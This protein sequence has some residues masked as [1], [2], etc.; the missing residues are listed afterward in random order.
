MTRTL[1]AILC[2]LALSLVAGA[3]G[4]DA[5]QAPTAQPAAKSKILI[6]T[7]D[8]VSPAHDWL[9]CASASREVLLE[10]KR[11]DVDVVGNA[12]VL[13]NEANLKGVDAIYLM[14]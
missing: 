8:D 1:R 7:G 9:S 14:L 12:E 10:S 4:L 6:I 11:F 5:A 3:A 13:A 2:L